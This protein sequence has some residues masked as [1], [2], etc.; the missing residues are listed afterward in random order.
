MVKISTECHRLNYCLFEQPCY[1]MQL[2]KKSI[3][4]TAVVQT[5]NVDPLYCPSVLLPIR[6]TA[7]P[8][9]CNI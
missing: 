4:Q 6:Y 7:H 1:H 9:Y 3:V 2:F 5:G 8:T